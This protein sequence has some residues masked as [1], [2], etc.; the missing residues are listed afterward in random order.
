MGSHAASSVIDK[1][2]TRPRDESATEFLRDFPALVAL[3]RLAVPILAVDDNG[4]IEFAN[5]AF[6]QMVGYSRDELVTKT[7]QSLV[8]CIRAPGAKVVSVLRE[9]ANTVIRLQHADGWTMPALISDSVL[10]RDHEKL[11][12]VAFTDLTEI[13]WHTSPYDELLPGH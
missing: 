7:A 13:S 2:Q 6:A 8:A 9:H 3:S 11:A 4:V 1:R 10:I 12:I 5:D